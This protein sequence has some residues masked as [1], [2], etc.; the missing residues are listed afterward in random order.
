MRPAS[1]R[2]QRSA[3]PVADNGWVCSLCFTFGP[4]LGAWFATRPLPGATLLGGKELNIY[5]T[6]AFIALIFLTVETAYLAWGLPETKGW[7]VEGGGEK[8]EGKVIVQPVQRSLEE[9]KMA[10][11][12]LKSL[13]RSFL[14]FFSGTSFKPAS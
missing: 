4:L 8:E 12:E 5:A 3:G 2:I 6:P 9:R 14:F 11:K 13:H 10:L 7:N 1:P